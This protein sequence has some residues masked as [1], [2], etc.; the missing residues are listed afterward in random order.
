L[1]VAREGDDGVD[2]VDGVELVAGAWARGK[3]EG[4]AQFEVGVHV[5]VRVGA[6]MEVREEQMAAGAKA[7]ELLLSIREGGSIRPEP[8]PRR[9]KPELV[10]CLF[11]S[12]LLPASC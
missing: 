4:D 11:A 9:S 8:R 6:H 5:E 10:C 7:E 1:C 2:D 3:M 12:K